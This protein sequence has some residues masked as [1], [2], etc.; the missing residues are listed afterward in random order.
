MD[1]QPH[2][3]E[4]LEALSSY[5]DSTA[6]KALCAE[7]ERHLAECPGCSVLVNT[8][9][10]TITLYRE[11]EATDAL[12]SEV[13]TRLFRAL[14]LDDL[15]AAGTSDIESPWLHRNEI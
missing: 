2:C 8:L 5:V 1:D 15:L 13:R 12:P 11:S 4:L 7:I 6:A 10:K 9:R 14:S 3:T